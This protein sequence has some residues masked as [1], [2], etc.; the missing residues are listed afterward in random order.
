[1]P[2]RLTLTSRPLALACSLALIGAGLALGAP[3]A[4]AAPDVTASV[5]SDSP[6]AAMPPPTPVWTMTVS[7][8]GPLASG[9]SYTV[10]VNS[11]VDY[12]ACPAIAPTVTFGSEGGTPS[13]PANPLL[14]GM[15]SPPWIIPGFSP[16]SCQ[17]VDHSCSVTLLSNRAGPYTIHAGVND[18]DIVSPQ[19]VVWVDN[20]TPVN[21]FT[22]LLMFLWEL[23][24]RLLNVEIQYAPFAVA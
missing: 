1:M 15:P 18:Q 6:C 4:S 19:Q 3:S 24:A 9:Q 11:S 10:T 22:R 23:L 21:W 14:L 5:T 13:G 2:R 16:E 17:V 20:S 7:P 8:S 12:S